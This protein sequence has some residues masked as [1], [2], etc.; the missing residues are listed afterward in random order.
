M[1]ARQVVLN[2]LISMASNPYMGPPDPNPVNSGVPGDFVD[3]RMQLARPVRPKNS[4]G[5]NLAAGIED[6]ILDGAVYSVTSDNP[7]TLRFTCSPEGWNGH[8][9]VI[10]VTSMVSESAPAALYL[11]LLF[12]SGNVLIIEEPETHLYPAMQVET[13]RHL[14]ALADAVV[15]E[16]VTT[17]SEGIIG[18]PSNFVCGSR[19]PHARRKRA[20]LWRG[21]TVVWLAP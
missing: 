4:H 9:N 17:H 13:D 6:L 8:L 7:D 15:R 11:R 19:P 1:L 5:H 2:G 12:G 16:I 21:Q 3:G 18:E 10:I 20:A 14:A